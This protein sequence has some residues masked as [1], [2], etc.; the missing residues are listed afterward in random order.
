MG[1]DE[2]VLS[3]C[4]TKVRLKEICEENSHCCFPWGKSLGQNSTDS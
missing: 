3:L 4:G 2:L 1:T